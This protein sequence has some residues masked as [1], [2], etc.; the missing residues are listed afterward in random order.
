MRFHGSNNIYFCYNVTSH[1]GI[2]VY[3]PYGTVVIR[4]SFSL[5][6]DWKVGDNDGRLGGKEFFKCLPKH[7]KMVRLG[8]IHAVMNPRV[9]NWLHEL[10][11]YAEIEHFMWRHCRHVGG[12]KQHIFSPLGNKIC[13]HAKLFHCFS[14]P[15]WPLWKPSISSLSVTFTWP[16]DLATSLIIVLHAWSDY[17]KICD[18]PRFSLALIGQFTEDSHWY[19]AVFVFVSTVSVKLSYTS[20]MM[21]SK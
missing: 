13:F 3:V 16:C 8:D 11:P 19:G 14:S 18:L 17:A 21:L 10:S 1:S 7:G 5:F 20:R 12:Q 6:S 4:I 9:R 15:I 2:L